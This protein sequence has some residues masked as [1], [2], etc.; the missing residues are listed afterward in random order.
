MLGI[1]ALAVG[2]G[3]GSVEG[4]ASALGGSLKGQDSFYI[5]GH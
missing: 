5:V 4:V 3:Q 2:A 1:F